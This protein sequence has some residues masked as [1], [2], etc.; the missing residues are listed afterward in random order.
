MDTICGNRKF[1]DLIRNN[2]ISKYW[3]GGGN[4][5]GWIGHEF[6][7]HRF[8]FFFQDKKI[9][10]YE[11]MSAIFFILKKR[12]KSEYGYCILT[13]MAPVSNIIK[14]KRNPPTDRGSPGWLAH[15]I[16]VLRKYVLPLF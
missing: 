3:A 16:L 5:E 8:L 15:Y 9:A 4:L 7:P 14:Q 13:L 11:K 12:Y 2:V 6:A 10:D 1:G